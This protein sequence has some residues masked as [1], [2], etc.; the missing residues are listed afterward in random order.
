MAKK[1]SLEIWG[2]ESNIFLEK[3]VGKRRFSS[4]QK[5]MRICLA[6]GHPRTLLAPG[7]QEPLH[8]TEFSS[9]IFGCRCSRHANAARTQQLQLKLTRTILIHS[10]VRV[11]SQSIDITHHLNNHNTETPD[12]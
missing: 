1:R 11:C 2:D 5:N 8:A 12:F 10:V 4:E 9:T 3:F 6:P 7:F